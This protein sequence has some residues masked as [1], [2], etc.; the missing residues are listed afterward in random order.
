MRRV[1]DEYQHSVSG[2]GVM[3]KGNTKCNGL[4]RA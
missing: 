4:F 3:I 1:D 2:N